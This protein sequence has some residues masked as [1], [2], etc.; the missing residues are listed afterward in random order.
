M[1]MTLLVQRCYGSLGRKRRRAYAPI[2]EGI[3]SGCRLVYAE[4]GST[5]GQVP[6]GGD[7]ESEYGQRRELV[8]E[9]EG[10]WVLDVSGLM[11][12]TINGELAGG[13]RI[14]PGRSE[15]LNPRTGEWEEG[16]SLSVTDFDDPVWFLRLFVITDL[17]LVGAEGEVALPIRMIDYSYTGETEV[18]GRRAARY[19]YRKVEA[20][21]GGLRLALVAVEYFRDN[22]LLY[23]KSEYDFFPDGGLQFV[24]SQ[25]LTELAVEECPE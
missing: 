2:L 17:S 10:R 23:R 12:Y 19:E 3:S 9:D 20:S 6:G 15:N 1:D 25:T 16:Q 4:E 24:G 8:P 5:A 7:F 11:T 22:P 21:E 13:I 18:G 14:G